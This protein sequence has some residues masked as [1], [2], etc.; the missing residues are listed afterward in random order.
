MTYKFS[1]QEFDSDARRS[2]IVEK[3]SDWAFYATYVATREKNRRACHSVRPHFTGEVFHDYDDAMERLQS[4]RGEYKQNVVQY[5]EYP[6]LNDTPEMA[7]IQNAIDDAKKRLDGINH[8]VYYAN[9]ELKSK[10]IACKHCEAVIPRQFFGNGNVVQNHC[11]F[12]K[13]DLRPATIRKRADKVNAQIEDLRKQY[14][15]AKRRNEL[16]H[17]AEA[18]KVWIALLELDVPEK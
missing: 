7:T 3:C 15:D 16:E 14:K 13:T 18:K 17:R 6:E 2:D 10:R 4:E 12:C 8:V 1:F 11:P 5:Y 9:P